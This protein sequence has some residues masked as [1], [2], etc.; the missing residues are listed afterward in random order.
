[1]TVKRSLIAIFVVTFSFVGATFEEE[2]DNLPPDLP[3]EPEWHDV[4]PLGQDV[5]DP[6]WQSDQDILPGRERVVR[7]HSGTVSTTYTRWG[8]KVC[9]NGAEL[10][11]DGVMAGSGHTKSGGGADYLCLPIV[12]QYGSTVAGSQSNRDHLYGVE[13]ET[14]DFDPAFR[15]VNQHD[16]PCAVCRVVNRGSSLMIP[17]WNSCP[18]GWV[19]EYSGYLM[20]AQLYTHTYSSSSHHRTQHICVDEQPETVYWTSSS[21]DGALLYFVEARCTAGGGIP[22]GP[23]EDGNELTC[24]VCTV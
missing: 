16:A 7:Q 4:I 2:A 6:A 11:Y 8:R 23:Y 15:D 19:R 21:Q 22:C 1:M 9:P 12:P 10:V 3:T 18:P 13:Y 17:G 24:A 14:S 5:E 20:S